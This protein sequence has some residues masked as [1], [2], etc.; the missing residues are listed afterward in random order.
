MRVWTNTS[1]RSLD[2][3]AGPEPPPEAPSDA[4]GAA[5]AE[6]SRLLRRVAAEGGSITLLRPDAGVRYLPIVARI[7]SLADDSV[8]IGRPTYRP[9]QR[10][11]AP[12]ER[13]TLRLGFDD[14]SYEGETSVLVKYAP[15]GDGGRTTTYKLARP[16]VLVADD[17]RGG[18]RIR[19]AYEA[20]PQAEFFCAPRH[21]PLGH[22]HVVDLAAGGLRVRSH[23]ANLRAGDRVVVR[24][25][26]SDD[27]RVHAIG[28]VVHA[29]PSADGAT[30]VGVRFQ[31][32]QPEIERFIRS[33][34]VAHAAR[35]L[36]R[37]A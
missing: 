1:F 15:D 13:L 11:M 6:V 16:E 4:A 31:T 10:A 33:V 5:A 27:A 7:E 26:L 37:R 9:G 17:R 28:V 21:K 22:G 32:S 36:A 35:H 23:D 8:T 29:G 24:A 2:L 34:S 18:E 20:P 19:L 14:G 25:R 3:L 12:G 30:D